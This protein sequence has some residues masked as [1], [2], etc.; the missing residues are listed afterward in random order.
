MTSREVQGERH[1][2]PDIG[3]GEQRE[4][5]QGTSFGSRFLRQMREGMREGIREIRD[6]VRGAIDTVRPA[7]RRTGLL[8]QPPRQQSQVPSHDRRRA[9]KEFRKLEPETFNGEADLN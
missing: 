8:A 7:H 4:R 3:L 6:T 9:L 1:D 2:I 5:R